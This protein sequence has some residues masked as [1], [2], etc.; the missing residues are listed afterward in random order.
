MHTLV[1]R[2][3]IDPQLV[4]ADSLKMVLHAEQ[5]LVDE[6]QRWSDNKRVSSGWFLGYENGSHIVGYYPRGDRIVCP[7]ATTACAEFIIREL[8][9]I[10]SHS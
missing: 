2:S 9:G 6:W 3:R 8:R 4:T 7:D 1:H 10:W 5:A